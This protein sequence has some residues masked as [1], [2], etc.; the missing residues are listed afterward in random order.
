MVSAANNR[1]KL[2]RRPIG[3][4]HSEPSDVPGNSL[5]VMAGELSRDCGHRHGTTSPG[6]TTLLVFGGHVTKGVRAED[7]TRAWYE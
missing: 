6:A 2:A 1:L 3:N 5:P 4:L 7:R